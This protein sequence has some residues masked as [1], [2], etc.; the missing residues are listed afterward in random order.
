MDKLEQLQKELNELLIK[1]D[2]ER[3][4][5]RATWSD[6]YGG[7]QSVLLGHHDRLTVESNG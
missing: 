4:Q 5:I 1:I 2:W 7:L 6:E 3:C